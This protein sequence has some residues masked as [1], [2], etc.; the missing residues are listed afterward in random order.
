MKKA[1]CGVTSS[2]GLAAKDMAQVVEVVSKEVT[3]AQLEQA[4]TPLEDQLAIEFVADLAFEVFKEETAGIETVEEINT[5]FQE[6]FR[7]EDNVWNTTVF[8]K[9]QDLYEQNIEVMTDELD[10]KLTKVSELFGEPGTELNN[11]F[12]LDVLKQFNQRGYGLTFSKELTTDERE[13]WQVTVN[14]VDILL[15]IS[16]SR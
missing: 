2:N 8:E 4:F 15:V 3:D 1:N 16:A 13:N 6:L 12:L 11:P 9:L 5:K 14:T 10:V 7:G